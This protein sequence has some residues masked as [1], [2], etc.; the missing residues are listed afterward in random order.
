MESPIHI[1][2]S[3]QKIVI[4]GSENNEYNSEIKVI[5]KEY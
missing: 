4:N 5:W 3:M 1:F 2:E